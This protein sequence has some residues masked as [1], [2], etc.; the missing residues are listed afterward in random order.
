MSVQFS[1]RLA[2]WMAVGLVL[3]WVLPLPAL[4]FEPAENDD[5]YLGV[6]SANI[7]LRENNEL[8]SGD[9]VFGGLRIGLFWTVFL[10]LGYGAVTYSDSVLVGTEQRTINFRTTGPHG[11]LGFLIPIRAI[12][13]GVK[14]QRSVNNRWAEEITRTLDGTTISNVSGRIDY[15]SYYVFARL[16]DKGLFE[17][18]VRRDQ[19]KS[20]DSVLSNAFGPYLA[21]NISI[22]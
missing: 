4:A 9:N 3:A 8:L 22:E 10:E 16:G 6:G 1:R 12:L 21:V 19:I 18:G 20:T 13:L 15:I 5:F 2:T 11:G 17:V 14:A 7:E